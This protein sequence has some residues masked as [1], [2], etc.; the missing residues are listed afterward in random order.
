MTTA[1]WNILL[2]AIAG[3]VAGL[4]TQFIVPGLRR[5]LL[6]VK[7]HFKQCS[8]RG[9][10]GTARIC[11]CYVLPLSPRSR[12]SPSKTTPRTS[13]SHPS[14]LR[15]LSVRATL[16]RSKMIGFAGRALLRSQ[17][18]RSSTFMAGKNRPW[19]LSIFRMVILR[20]PQKTDGR[21]TRRKTRS[22]SR[23]SGGR[24]RAFS[25]SGRNTGPR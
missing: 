22:T 10:R 6:F 16:E 4:L 24:T 1:Q 25:L 15:L 9:T 14:T 23:R 13:L 7:L 8:K 11:N 2:G 5:H 19:I 17:I 18:P 12:I 21:P 3:G 20:F